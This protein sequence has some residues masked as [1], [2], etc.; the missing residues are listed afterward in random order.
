MEKFKESKEIEKNINEVLELIEKEVG[1]ENKVMCTWGSNYVDIDIINEKENLNYADIRIFDDG[2]YSVG[3]DR[4]YNFEHIL[5]N[6]FVNVENMFDNKE[7]ED[8]LLFD[9]KETFDEMSKDNQEYC[10]TLSREF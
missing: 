5:D 4:Y 8:L 10:F 7:F 3:N 6:Y 9:N 2:L 1:P